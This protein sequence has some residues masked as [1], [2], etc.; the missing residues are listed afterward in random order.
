M[1]G[2]LIAFKEFRVASGFLKSLFTS[3]WVGLDNFKFLFANPTVWMAIRNT[4][5]YN[6]ALITLGLVVP[7]T[8]AII[9]SEVWNKRLAKL[10]QT[11]MFFPF[12]ISWVVV[13]ALVMGF[14]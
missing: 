1:V 3:R 5:L 4:L 8:L 6:A 10:Y 12:F 14:L 11:L 2:V 13:S 7:V 9:I